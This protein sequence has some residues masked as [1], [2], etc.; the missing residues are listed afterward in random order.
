[1]LSRELRVNV[2][3]SS[4]ISDGKYMFDGIVANV[5]RHGVK[6]VD[7]PR[8]FDTRSR[9]CITVIMGGGRHFKFFVQPRWSREEGLY[10]EVGFEI[11]SPPL[12][13]TR[14]LNE[15]DPAVAWEH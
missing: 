5:S 12:S 1:M 10:K 6:I 9:K 7:I 13:W 4:S 3:M 14:F 8:K 2:T 11:V 15:L